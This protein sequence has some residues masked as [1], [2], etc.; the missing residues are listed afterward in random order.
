MKIAHDQPLVS[1]IMPVYNAAD[2]LTETIHS[3]LEQTYENFE[4][5]AI[6]DGSTD[7]SLKILQKYSKIDTRIKVIS[8]ENKGLVKT[9]NEAIDRSSGDFLARIDS[10]DLCTP[11]RLQLQVEAFM[12][13]PNAAL[14]C[15]FFEIFSEEGEFISKE[16][17]PYEQF[18]L[19]RLLY[20]RNAIA[21]A[22]VM[23]RKSA[24]PKDPYSDKVGPTE[25]YELW[26][27]LAKDYDFICIPKIIM[28]YRVNTNG[29]MHTIG[30]QQWIHMERNINEYW[31]RMG[32]PPL[33]KISDTRAAMS[34]YLYETRLKG[35][36]PEIIRMMLEAE[37][38]LAIKCMKRGLVGYGLKLFVLT[39][40]SSRT[41]LRACRKKIYVISK[42]M[43]SSKLQ[44]KKKILANTHSSAESF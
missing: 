35:Y 6:N 12:K 28:R 5:I 10:D 7:D 23:L 25:D 37:A 40:L 39:A 4:V 32:P 19:K 33:R 34:K 2:F 17:R 41:G 16:V 30:D 27:R 24:L 9:L 22:S 21:H 26:S 44:P 38:Q 13:N 36:G 20:T 1:F 43:L 42:N 14:C 18:D 11:N 8:R 15:G 3:I 31:K 29:I